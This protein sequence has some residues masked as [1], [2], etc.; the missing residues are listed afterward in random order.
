MLIKI[1]PKNPNQKALM[2]VIDVLER[3]GVIVYPTDTVYAFGCSLKSVKAVEKLKSIKSR[4]K[5]MSIIC[6]DISEISA[7]AKVDNHTFKLLKRN[8]PGAFTFILN[9]S[10]K[11]PDKFLEKRKTIG[12]RIP[13]NCIVEAITELLGCPLVTTSVKDPDEVIEYTTDPE[14]I[15]ERYGS[16]IDLVIDGGYGE[17]VASTVVDCTG[18]EV[19]ILRQ[20]IGELIL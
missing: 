9:A 17:N 8:L 7:Y 4:K 6:R 3:D 12:V 14:L 20:G 16:Q 10:G 2:Q 18:D 11:V 19:E 15:H 1:Y 5:N 13:E